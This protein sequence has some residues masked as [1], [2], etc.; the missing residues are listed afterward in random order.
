MRG[1]PHVAE[2]LGW[3]ETRLD[4]G[5]GHPGHPVP[6]PARRLDG[7]SLAATSV[8]DLYAAEGRIGAAEAGGDFAGEAYRLGEATAE[9]HRDL[10]RAFGTDELP[11]EAISALADEMFQRL[12]V[13]LATVPE[14]GRHADLLGSAFADLAKLDTR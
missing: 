3:I 12:D 10:A 7:W 11:P 8:R 2:P 9:V 14:L 6:L 13:A 1:S 4:G 5:P